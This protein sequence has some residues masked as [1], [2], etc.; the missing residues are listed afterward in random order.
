MGPTRGE[1]W[2]VA[3]VGFASDIRPKKCLGQLYLSATRAPVPILSDS[4]R[5]QPGR[6][7]GADLVV[8]AR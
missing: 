3:L 8:Q 4:R 7:P 2:L 1:P 6:M 5:Q